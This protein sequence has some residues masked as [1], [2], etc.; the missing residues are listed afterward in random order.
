MRR[1]CFKLCHEKFRLDTGENFFIKRLVRH[2]NLLPRT[3]VESL[4][5]EEFKR[6]VALGD[7][8]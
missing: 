8:V 4:P 3:V 1:N 2:W 7:M 5:L 6:H